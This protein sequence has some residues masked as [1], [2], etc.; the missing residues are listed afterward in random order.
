MSEPNPDEHVEQG[1]RR[2]FQAVFAYLSRTKANSKLD[3]KALFELV[4]KVLSKMEKGVGPATWEGASPVKIS[5]LRKAASLYQPFRIVGSITELRDPELVHV[6][7]GEGEAKQSEATCMKITGID[8]DSI[9]SLDVVGAEIDAI[10]DLR[11]LGGLT[12][13]LCMPV[14][15]PIRIDHARPDQGIGQGRSTFF[16]HV[17]DA[18]QSTSMLDLLG[19]SAEERLQ[20]EELL[21]RLHERGEAPLDYLFER[22]VKKLNIVGLDEFK[23]LRD[24]LRFAV[25]QS[26][27]TGKVDHAPGC[28]HGLVVGPPGQGKKLVGMVARVL[29]PVCIELSPTKVSA[30]GLVGASVR[31][32]SGWASQPGALPRAAHGVAVLQ[33]AH[34]WEGAEVRRLAPTFQELMEDGVVR[35]S[36]AGA[37]RRAAPTALLIDLNRTA[38]VGLVGSQ[39]AGL[40]RIRPLISR[41][42]CIIEMP[43]DAHRSW[44]VARKLYN[45]MGAG[46][47]DLDHQPW[48]R[49]LRLLVALL[50][51]T[52]RNVDLDPVREFMVAVH[53]DVY[54][55]NQKKFD[56]MPEAADI[57]AR[58]AISFCRFV[59]A[60]ARGRGSAVASPA[61]VDI[62][63]TFINRKLKFL[64][65]EGTSY[66]TS[67]TGS[68]SSEERGDWFAKY[69]GREV[70]SQDVV[71]DYREQTGQGMSE[72]T[73]R[74]HLQRLGGLRTGRGQY[75]LPPGPP[76]AGSESP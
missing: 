43:E 71:K 15:L 2:L 35:D 46:G 63:A 6:P 23:E 73:A 36:V 50:R 16:V 41:F 34:G 9:W 8:G 67:V 76:V 58:L 22:V 11:R 66:P 62:A 49:K 60:A 24:A 42:D 31:T 10:L 17:L 19:A 30:A 74:R 64:E 55:S 56:G 29:N 1:M 72:R 65:V 12:E 70:R 61:D 39:E 14:D 3:D 18:R 52:N 54:S 21:A 26:L 37:E 33:D 57:P 25:L 38:Q 45:S 27:S 47:A 5:S 7:N 75:M 53:D 44:T 4:K 20:A 48:V 40:L 28:L 13:F 69:A 51:D 59:A 68:T 32:A